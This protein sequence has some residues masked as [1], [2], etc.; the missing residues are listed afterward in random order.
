MRHSL[1]YKPKPDLCLLQE[2]VIVHY[3]RE[4]YAKNRV[5]AAARKA[6]KSRGIVGL[7]SAP[8]LRALLQR[9]PQ[10]LQDQYLYEKVRPDATNSSVLMVFFDYSKKI[11]FSG[12]KICPSKI[13]FF[14]IVELISVQFKIMYITKMH[15]F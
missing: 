11:I 15:V 7:S 4:L 2:L 9:L 10:L 8:C 12:K 1:I 3:P 13:S 5:L 6:L 14:E